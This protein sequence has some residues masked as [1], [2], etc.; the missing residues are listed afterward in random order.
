[1]TGRY[2]KEI[3]EQVRAVVGKM[4][5]ELCPNPSQAATLQ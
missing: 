4:D 5:R 2:V 1:M 3:P